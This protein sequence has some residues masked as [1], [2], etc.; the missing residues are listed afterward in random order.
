M[1][2]T[3]SEFI[4]DLSAFSKKQIDFKNQ[5]SFGNQ[6]CTC[7]LYLRL[8][9]S[10]MKIPRPNHENSS[11]PLQ[12]RPEGLN[13]PHSTP[14]PNHASSTNFAAPLSPI[15]AVNSNGSNYASPLELQPAAQDAGARGKLLSVMSKWAEGRS[16]VEHLVKTDRVP[17]KEEAM[18]VFQ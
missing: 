2:S 18:L 16:H 8:S 13:N 7:L 1:Q 12:A 15:D 9:N 11:V 10:I 3:F 5:L 6:M 17:Q 4:L 14:H